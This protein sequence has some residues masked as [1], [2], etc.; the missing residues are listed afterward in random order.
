MNEQ[1]IETTSKESQ[2]LTEEEIK[3]R[4][5]EKA[6]KL[7][8]AYAL[9]LCA[10]SVSQIVEYQDL[11]IMEQEYDTILNNLN[12]EEMPKDE[13][14]LSIIKQILDVITFFR[15]QD[16]DRKMIE[17]EFQHRQKNAIW[18]SQ[19]NIT[20]L[21]GNTPAS[22]VAS[23]ATQVGVG[24]MN[25]RKQKAENQLEHEKEMWKLQRSAIEQL[26][27]LR[28]ELFD[29]AWRLADTHKFPDEYRL[30]ERQI[31]RY[32]KVLMDTDPLR[33]Y[34]RLDYM[35]DMF[36][37]YPPFWYQLG[38]A[39]N[40]VYESDKKKMRAYQDCAI[41]HYDAFLEKT[42]HN[43]LREDQLKA[44]CALEKFGICAD[45]KCKRKIAPELPELIQTAIKS[46]G[47]AY[48]VHQ[49]CAMSYLSIGER[50]KA[51]EELRM[52]VNEGYNTA[53]NAQLLSKLYIDENNKKKTPDES[54]SVEYDT[55][56]KRVGPQFLYPWTSDEAA[57]LKNQ[58]EVLL[59]KYKSVLCQI[60]TQYTREYN[61]AMPYSLSTPAIG[62]NDDYLDTPEIICKRKQ[63][64]SKAF[65]Q[66]K[67]E[68]LQCVNRGV[69]ERLEVLNK[70]C[71]QIEFLPGYCSSDDFYLK[72]REE[73]NKEKSILQKISSEKDVDKLIDNL[74]FTN[75]AN[76]AFESVAEGI[77]ASIENCNGMDELSQFESALHRYCDKYQLQL[78]EQTFTDDFPAMDT[79]SSSRDFRELMGESFENNREKIEWQNE[80]VEKAKEYKPK[81]FDKGAEK[82][83][84]SVRNEPQFNE[85]FLKINNKRFEK[86][87]NQA[88]AVLDDQTRSNNDLVLLRHHLWD[89]GTNGF[90][91]KTEDWISY[92][93]VE[94]SGKGLCIGGKNIA[95]KGLNCDEF[96]KMCHELN[97]IVEKHSKPEQNDAQLARIEGDLISTVNKVLSSE[98]S[99]TD[100]TS[101]PSTAYISVP[102][103]D[104]QT[105]MM[106][107]MFNDQCEE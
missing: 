41:T 27:A 88:V 34:E 101:V 54:F 40:E 86:Y 96:Y 104:Y 9:N 95:Y 65:K 84:F 71:N 46:A 11:Y 58:K 73:L 35:K 55:L 90:I 22:I 2:Q 78:P 52:L 63:M 1:S 82:V 8:E 10:V 68:Y 38:H 102:T 20:G 17:K 59:G 66:N 74:C 69:S 3:K 56:A 31:K 45:R 72:I 39:A 97:S 49:I 93:K 83:F 80:M 70:L 77:R 76:L 48:D 51:K 91:S 85:Y 53:L 4:K 30:T 16:G 23:L 98:I 6:Q 67:D 29:T 75:V 19:P 32:N 21:V 57:F 60:I 50:G 99:R 105:H 42:N 62:D 12:L 28:R 107:E 89:G 13:A 92:K 100:D 5:E 43:L 64:A 106:C 26:N 47:N 103:D 81:L 15:M 37:A 18:S 79:L 33:R 36:E 14:L 25:Y 7:K 94:K 61:Q 44:S 24:Y 87:K